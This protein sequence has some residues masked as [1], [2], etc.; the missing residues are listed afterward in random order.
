MDI[1]DVNDDFDITVENRDR[2]EMTK[3]L[4]SFTINKLSSKSN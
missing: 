2:V 4:G 3:L 1:K